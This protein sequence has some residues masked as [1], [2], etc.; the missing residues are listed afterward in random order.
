VNPN[1][2]ERLRAAVHEAIL[3]GPGEDAGAIAERILKALPRY[4]VQLVFARD[5]RPPAT[6]AEHVLG[7]GKH[8]GESIASVVQNHRAYA[9]WLAQN[10]KGSVHRA[11]EAELRRTAAEGA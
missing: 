3:A 5:A 11:L 7:F 2:F 10:S 8:K 1:A 9:T 4:E 6:A